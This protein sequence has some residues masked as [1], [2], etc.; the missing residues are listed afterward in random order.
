M[1]RCC[2]AS[3]A[4]GAAPLAWAEDLSF[5]DAI[6]RATVDGPTIAAGES[7]VEAAA[8]RIAPADELPDPKLVLGVRNV[9]VS[10]ADQFT[11]DR[12]F[13]TRTEVGVMQ[14]VPNRAKR[15]ARTRHARAAAKAADAGLDTT[16]LE[17]R[18]AA[19]QAWIEVYFGYERLD[20][21]AAL[22]SELAAL[23]ESE[24]ERL[25]SGQD[26]ADAAI[27]ARIEAS[28]LEDRRAVVESDV[29]ASRAELERWIGDTGDIRPGPAVPTFAI[30]PARMRSHVRDH[31]AVAAAAAETSLARANVELARSERYSDWSWDV[32]YGRREPSFSDMIS[33][34]VTF[35]LPLFQSSRQAPRIEAR[36]ADLQRA[37][38]EQEA[39]LRQYRAHL[40]GMLADHAALIDQLARLNDVRLP[41]A[42]QRA[43]LARSGLAAGSQSV[44]AALKARIDVLEMEFEQIGLRQQTAQLGAV[45]T[46]EHGERVQ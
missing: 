23:I 12:D 25:A 20:L 39:V 7:A 10:G 11:L 33:V 41:L 30:E 36:Y 32:M 29:V 26:A 37:R 42:R 35:S 3:C 5:T 45:L 8:L 14:E 18:L 44:D 34:G 1:L 17:A 22:E 38:A 46:L 2:I 19:A 21:L 15:T 6:N 13:M 4:L 24:E 31:V 16:R 27:A 43:E 9:P 40:D 28:R